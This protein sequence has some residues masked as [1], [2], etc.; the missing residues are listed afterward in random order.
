M[1]QDPES[2]SNK[3]LKEAARELERKEAR[4]SADHHPSK[5]G[6]AAEVQV[7]QGLWRLC[8]VRPAQLP[9]LMESRCC[10]P[11]CLP[12]RLQSAAA[13]RLHPEQNDVVALVRRH[14]EVALGGQPDEELAA[15]IIEVGGWVLGV[16]GCDWDWMQRRHRGAGWGGVGHGVEAHRR[17]SLNPRHASNALAP[18]AP[19][20]AGCRGA[21]GAQA[22][23]QAPSN[24]G[25]GA[26]CGG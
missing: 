2:V 16:G 12:A 14:V 22:A 9:L 13:H 7:C 23:G 20:P 18:L 4:A 1:L 5:G 17:H 8:P 10:V 24:G 25:G 6:L 21:G 15:A 11:T 26:G 3:A 19:L